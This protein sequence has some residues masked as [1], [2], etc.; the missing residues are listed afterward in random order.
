MEFGNVF[1][2]LQWYIRQLERG[3]GLASN[4]GSIMA[5]K[6]YE[7]IDM[8]GS[9]VNTADDELIAIIDIEKI[10]S[11]FPQYKRGMFLHVGMDC[12]HYS[13]DRWNCAYARMKLK[14]YYRNKYSDKE[15][16]KK[17]KE[18]L[19]QLEDVL[20]REEYVTDK[21]FS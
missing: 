10:L 17:I 9:V 6:G 14:T 12:W 3:S 20:F 4:W 15:L 7:N 19:S 5:K 16:N 21:I 18:C 2:L 8:Q 1:K 13:E 11:K